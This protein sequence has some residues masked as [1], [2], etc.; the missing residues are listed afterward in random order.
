MEQKQIF[1]ESFKRG[2][3]EQISSGNLTKQE[4]RKKYGIKGNSAI[5]S[6]QRNLLQYGQCC[7]T[8]SYKSYPILPVKKPSKEPSSTELQA[9]IKQLE[10]QLEDEQIRSEAYSRMIDFAEKELSI[11]IRKKPGTK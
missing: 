3:L 1:S 8:L 9:R 2:V 4:A 6:W 5:L 7:L 11:P 10:R